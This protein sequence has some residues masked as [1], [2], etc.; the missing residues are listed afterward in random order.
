MIAFASFAPWPVRVLREREPGLEALPVAAVAAGRV[1]ALSPE[2]RAL[3][4]REG[5]GE[6]VARKKSDHLALRPLPA[7]LEAAWDARL[8]E[9]SGFS[10]R[11]ESPAPGEALLELDGAGARA[12][13]ATYRVPVGLGETRERARLAAA[14][15]GPG[16]AVRFPGLAGIPLEALRTVGLTPEGLRRLR[17]LGA[18]TAADLAAWS[19]PQIEAFLPEGRALLPYL[20]GPG[21]SGVAVFDPGPRVER[22]VEFLEPV[23]APQALAALE[24]LAGELDRA[25]GRRAAGR[26]FL[27]VEA[28]GLRFFA[29]RRPKEPLRGRRRLRLH[30]E[31]ALR[32]SGALAFPVERVRATLTGLR[33]PGQ[34]DGLFRRTGD[35]AEAFRR[36]PGA[37]VRAVI[38]DPGSPAAE[39]A[40]TYLPREVPDAPD[41]G[42]GRARARGGAA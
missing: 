33:T 39:H 13:A 28:G 31:A 36:F 26:L 32:G 9:L 41:P 30:L 40:F 12:L 29:E 15:A 42:S 1:V 27:E 6:A 19:T 25:L 37:F 18:A 16:E 23:E 14:L 17:W 24:V 35:L 21:R 38:T 22:V 20:K 34:Q 2:A 5:M 10:P 11:L 3:G 4:I 8:F 7:G